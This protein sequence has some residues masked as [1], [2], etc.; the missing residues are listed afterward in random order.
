VS[1]YIF[2]AILFLSI[3]SIPIENIAQRLLA[4]K[5][6]ELIP[7]KKLYY[8]NKIYTEKKVLVLTWTKECVP[9]SV[10][11]TYHDVDN[12]F[13]G[14]EFIFISTSDDKETGVRVPIRC[15]EKI[16]STEIKE[17]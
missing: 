14:G 4:N 16:E 17:T 8:F 11:I 3:L 5:L 7:E 10:R 13:L 9:K 2:A 6:I 15:L 12:V 1:K